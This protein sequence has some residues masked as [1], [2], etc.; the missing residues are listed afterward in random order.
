[1]LLNKEMCQRL[2]DLHNTSK[3]IF[4][5][6]QSVIL[7]NDSWVRGLFTVQ[8]RSMDFKVTDYEKFISIILDLSLQQTFK[9][10]TCRI[11]M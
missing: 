7:Q 9:P 8:D 1:M 11:L 6:G 10:A 2:E 4:P 5:N 3:P